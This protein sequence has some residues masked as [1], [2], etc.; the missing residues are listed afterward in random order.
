MLATECTI[1]RQMIGSSKCSEGLRRATQMGNDYV[2]TLIDY[3]RSVLGNK[4][5]WDAVQA[6]VQ[7][8]ETVVFLANHQSEA[9]AAFI[10]LLTMDSHPG[11]RS[12]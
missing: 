3:D 10:P 4:P 11:A 5:A 9:D 2:G 6:Q 12:L 8:G 1:D 7:A